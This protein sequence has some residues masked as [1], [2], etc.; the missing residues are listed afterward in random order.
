MVKISKFDFNDDLDDYIEQRKEDASPFERAVSKVKGKF[1][2]V[3]KIIE[4]KPRKKRRQYSFISSIFRRRIPSEEEIEEELG[5][6]SPQEKKELKQ[7]EEKIE[8]AEELDEEL[9]AQRESMI[10]RFLRKL[11]IYRRAQ[12]ED[13]EEDLQEEPVVDEEM[14]ELLKVL[15]KWLEQLPYDKKEQFK[16]SEDFQKY[17]ETLRRY[18]LIK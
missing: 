17:K 14:K 7:E 12:E 3:D 6:L 15:H 1:Q 18:N 16:R 10:T 13:Y 2:P 8:D 4:E 9:E 11:R 5:T